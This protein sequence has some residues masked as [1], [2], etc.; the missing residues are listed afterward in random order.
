MVFCIA[1]R[2]PVAA[3][4][5]LGLIGNVSATVLA[6]IGFVV[7]R[8]DYLGVSAMAILLMAVV[9]YCLFS[10][11][12]WVFHYRAKCCPVCHLEPNMPQKR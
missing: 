1:C 12:L 7:G 2:A 4:G 9:H 10:N 11:V 8:R 6:W 5:P 3:I